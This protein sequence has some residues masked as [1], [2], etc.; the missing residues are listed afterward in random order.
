MLSISPEVK[1][2]LLNNLFEYFVYL[3]ITKKKKNPLNLQ[4]LGTEGDNGEYRIIHDNSNSINN[5]I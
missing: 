5:M 2:G 4:F 1:F 3:T